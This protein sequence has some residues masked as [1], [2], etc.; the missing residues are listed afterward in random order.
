MIRRDFL[1]LLSAP[2]FG[3]IGL[4]LS[5]CGIHVGNSDAS[6][7]QDLPETLRIWSYYVPLTSYNGVIE[8]FDGRNPLDRRVLFDKVR[9][10]TSRI[11]GRRD[12]GTENRANVKV[13]DLRA[14]E[15]GL[16]IRFW[17]DDNDVSGQNGHTL[18]LFR[19]YLNLLDAGEKVY[20]ATGM[21]QGHFHVVMIDPTAA[22][23]KAMK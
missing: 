6:E 10:Q 7:T 22:G 12:D 4:R 20:V 14:A 9:N 17:H 8:D 18:H 21:I 23:Q 16:R 5:G 3:M 2:L 1:R 19:R 11:S 15:G 13:A